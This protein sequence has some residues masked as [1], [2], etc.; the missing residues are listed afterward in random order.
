MKIFEELESEVRSYSRNFPRIFKRAQGEFIYDEDENEYIDFLAGAG[1]LNYGHN[2]PIM[3]TKLIEYIESGGMTHS[4][5]LFT[6]AKREF[7]ET[8]REKILDKR[9]MDYR[10]MFTGP[11]GTNA[12]EASLKMARK[13]KQ[14]SHVIAFTNGWHGQTLG[15][16]SMT[17]NSHHRDGAGIALTGAHRL[18]YDGYLGDQLNTIEYLDKVLSDTSSGVDLPAACIVETIQGEGGVNY[19]SP[20]WLRGLSEVCK[21]HD[22]LLIIDDIQAG[23]GRSGS[24]FSFEEAGIEPDIVT[25]SKSL[26]GYG[27]PFAMVMFKPELDRW[28]PGEH[29]GTFRGNCHAF[30][31]AK[32]AIDT[33][34]SDDTFQQEVRKKGKYIADR[35]DKIVEKYGDGNFTVMGRGMFQGINCVNGEIAS[36]IT[37]A[38]FKKGLIIETSGTDDQIIKLLCPLIIAEE[39]LAKGIDII[40]ESIDEVCAN[41]EVPEESDYFDDVTVN[42]TKED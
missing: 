22:V 11:T 21:K 25:L 35:L 1:A 10:L 9:D 26:S 40:E 38:A 41:I 8:F 16:L 32:A 3:R 19:C 27:L 24:F 12:V 15:A 39:V 13:L 28:S 6:D 7:M 29:N 2:H 5:D 4:L 34:W 33:Y 31:T 37:R 42:D 36:K 23:C 17:A 30:V 14:R 18:P 20:E